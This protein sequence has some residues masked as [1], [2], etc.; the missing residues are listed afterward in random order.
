MDVTIWYT[1]CKG[2][3][4]ISN[5]DPMIHTYI[6]I[7][8]NESC[9]GY[10]RSSNIIIELFNFT[11]SGIKSSSNLKKELHQRNYISMIIK[12]YWKGGK[13]KKSREMRGEED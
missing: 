13:N 5:F 10:D 9:V 11:K 12:I 2:V 3:A 7:Y 8:N 6:H 4:H 1:H